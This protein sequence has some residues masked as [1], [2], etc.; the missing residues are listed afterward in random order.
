MQTHES[1]YCQMMHTQVAEN[2]IAEEK[3]G[4]TAVDN[5]SWYD[6]AEEMKEKRRG[7]AEADTCRHE[8]A[9]R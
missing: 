5:G 6:D 7:L 4:Q 9:E 8:E 1:V 3:E 2:D